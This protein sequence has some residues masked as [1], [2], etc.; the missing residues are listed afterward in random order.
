MFGNVKLHQF[1]ENRILLDEQHV[2]G[3]RCNTFDDRSAMRQQHAI[4]M[5]R[6]VNDHIFGHENLHFAGQQTFGGRHNAKLPWRHFKFAANYLQ[7]FVDV[8]LFLGN[9]RIAV[10]EF[11]VIQTKINHKIYFDGMIWRRHRVVHVLFK[12]INS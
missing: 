7:C 5:Q 11:A 4:S 6:T 8:L 1:F 2:F 3:I 10:V 9:V 12:E